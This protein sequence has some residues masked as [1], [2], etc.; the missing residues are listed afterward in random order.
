MH[1]STSI[2]LA[3]APTGSPITLK[4]MLEENPLTF[5][6]IHQTYQTS[7]G[8]PTMTTLLFLLRISILPSCIVACSV[9]A[10]P[11]VC[12]QRG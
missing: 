4:V 5:I 3:V 1:L 9:R 11:G 12:P 8:T 2:A 7:D 6:H 10:S